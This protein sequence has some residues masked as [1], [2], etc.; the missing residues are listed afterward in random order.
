MGLWTKEQL[1]AFIK[2]NKL[3]TAQ[4][5]SNALKNLFA[6]T[7]QEMLEAEMDTH[8][9]YEK[10]DTTNKKTSNSRNGKGKKSIISEYGEQEIQVPRD[11]QGEFEPL[12]V[13]KHQSHVNGIEDQIIALYAKGVS[14]REIQ[15]HMEHIYGIEVSPTLISN[16]TNKIVPMIKEWQNR[17]LQHTFAVVFLDAI[18]FKVKQDGAIVNKAAYMVIGIDLDGNK[19][20]LGI[21]IGENESSKFWLSVLNDLKNRGVQD[22]LITCVDNLT[23][24]TQAIAASYPKTEIQKCIIHQIRN[25][26]RYVSYKDLKKVTADLKPIYKAAT[27]D[28]AKLELDKFE[29]TWG[30]KYPLI[31]RSWRTNW[32]ELATYF[33]YPPEIRK[34]IYTTNIIESYHRQL[35]KVT[36]GK[37]IFP[38]DEALL[39][40]LYL[41]TMDVIR[42]WTGRVQNWGQMLLQLSV[43]FP[44][45]VGH[46]LR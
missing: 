31:I 6:E 17:P 39:K 19:D 45:R 42:K 27:E 15:D 35:R 14:T 23:G 40:M 37:S 7:I 3:V 16:V 25:S 5:A 43:F 18:H 33:K 30:T 28:A 32:E 2:E 20:V 46:H 41:A 22:I 26:T 1:R 12:I 13:K 24:F 44:D 36:K 34:L 4:D 29:E 38:T 21:W 8:L 9:G 11:R 10:H